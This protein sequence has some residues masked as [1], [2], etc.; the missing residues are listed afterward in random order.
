LLEMLS[1]VGVH[2]EIEEARLIMEAARSLRPDILATLLRT[3]RQQKALRLCVGWAEELSL[4]WAARAREA[5]GKRI[6]ASRWVARVRGGR[7]L[8][9]KP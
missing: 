9:L 6:G 7:T 2:Q 1:E 5:A 8:I 4:P 3:C